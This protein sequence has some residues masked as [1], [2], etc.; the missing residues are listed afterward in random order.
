MLK[1]GHENY[2]KAVKIKS[3]VVAAVFI[4]IIALGGIEIRQLTDKEEYEKSG[5][6]KRVYLKEIIRRAREECRRWE[7]ENVLK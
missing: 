6:W 3:G 5:Q 2:E 4:I 7:V 1:R